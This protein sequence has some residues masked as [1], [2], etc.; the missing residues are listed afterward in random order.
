M[1]NHVLMGVSL[2]NS[3]RRCLQCKG[4]NCLK[5]GTW[6]VFEFKRRLGEKEGVVFL[7]G[8]DTPMHTIEYSKI[9]KFTGNIFYLHRQK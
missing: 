9:Q 1:K 3:R 7:R 5:R 8:L 4:C 6:S 2:K